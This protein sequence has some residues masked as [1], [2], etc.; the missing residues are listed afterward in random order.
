MRTLVAKNGTRN[1]SKDCNIHHS[2]LQV[3]S[4]PP[5][6]AVSC[7]RQVKIRQRLV[8]IVGAIPVPYTETALNL[9]GPMN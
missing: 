8:P 1:Y 9:N 7:T 4:S 3:S 5:V 2:L 6:A